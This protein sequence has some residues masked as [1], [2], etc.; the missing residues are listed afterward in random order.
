MTDK[1]LDPCG[2]DSSTELGELMHAA[3]CQA[4]ALLNR[5]TAASECH[6]SRQAHG[7]LRKSLADY[8]DAYMDQ[9]VTAAERNQVARK[10]QRSHNTAD[11]RPSVRS[12]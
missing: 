12:I 11:D 2:S 4:V 6:Y 5:S 8:A 1:T 9:P 3:V 10:H 7:I